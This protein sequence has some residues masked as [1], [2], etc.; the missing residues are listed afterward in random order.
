[1]SPYLL[2]HSHDHSAQ[3][4]KGGSCQ[5]HPIAERA[6]SGDERQERSMSSEPSAKHTLISCQQKRPHPLFSQKTLLG[7]ALR[8]LKSGFDKTKIL[9]YP[10]RI[11]VKSTGVCTG[12]TRRRTAI[13]NQRDCLGCGDSHSPKDGRSWGQSGLGVTHPLCDLLPTPCQLQIGTCQ[14]L[15]VTS[16]NPLQNLRVWW[17]LV[18][19]H[20]IT[21]TL[22]IP[23]LFGAVSQSY[24]K[25]YFLCYSLHFVSGKT[26]TRCIF[27]K[28]TTLMSLQENSP[29]YPFPGTPSFLKV[30]LRDMQQR[31]WAW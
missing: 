31:T 24:L 2:I 30:F 22:T 8:I 21:C 10:H 29:S 5:L 4:W 13:N 26:L 28:S 27:Y 14:L 16:R 20:Q 15:L 7:K 17:H 6:M 25:R 12:P 19:L 23:Q 11:L 9:F 3:S 18:P 1:M